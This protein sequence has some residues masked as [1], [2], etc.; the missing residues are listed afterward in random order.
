MIDI[1]A[2][3]E[4]VKAGEVQAVS[5]AI[6]LV[7]DSEAFG[8]ALLN[9]LGPGSRHARII[10]VTGYPGAGKSTLIDAM[11]SAY[12]G[13]GQTVAV[14][15][16]DVSSPRTGG[17]IL[18]DRIRMQQ[19]TG[20]R[21]VYIRSMATRGMTGGVGPATSDAVRVLDAAGYDVIVV[22]TVGV[23]QADIDIARTADIVVA[24]VA[25]GLGDEVQAMKAGL[26]EIADIVV[27]N[28]ADR[29][30]A[31]LAVRELRE[32]LPTVIP[33]VALNGKG[34]AELLDAIAA[35]GRDGAGRV[36]QAGGR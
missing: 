33:T 30:D 27:V 12:R 35:Q 15:A 1:P 9:R 13:R 24:V 7:E 36:R 26:L 20:D 11:V 22:E 14:L 3:V 2:L 28:K 17:A 23:G 32:W 8:A 19:H 31:D 5:R 6:T 16:V 18:G 25:P 4:R 34:I 29:H 10:G 21:G